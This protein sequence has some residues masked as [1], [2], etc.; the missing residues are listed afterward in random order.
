MRRAIE[1][2]IS[3]V[4][5]ILQI[6]RL[7]DLPPLDMRPQPLVE[8]PHTHKRRRYRH[9]QQQNREHGEDGQA[10]AGR[11]VVGRFARVVHAHEL[12][13]EVG[14]GGEV[15]GDDHRLAEVGL[16]AREEGGEEEERDGDGDRGD[17]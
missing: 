16:A 3:S 2:L 7:R 6:V 14:H 4:I 5:R 8:I 1:V 15:D 12:E 10:L 9:N 13:D 17:G 11:G